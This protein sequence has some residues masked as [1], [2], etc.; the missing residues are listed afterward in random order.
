[1]D[2]TVLEGSPYGDSEG[3]DVTFMAIANP[4]LYEARLVSGAVRLDRLLFEVLPPEGAPQ[5]P[6]G[7]GFARAPE[8][9]DWP[10]QDDPRRGLA[11]WTPQAADCVEPTFPEAPTLRLVERLTGDPEDDGDDRY[12]DVAVAFPGHPYHLEA[13]FETAPPEADYR[14]KVND[15][16]RVVVSRT[17]DPRLYRSEQIVLWQ[18]VSP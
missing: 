8:L 3:G 9:D 6:P 10:V 11:V 18:E 1:V 7:T 4:G 13:A 2:A 14:V 16:L 12:L 5:P 17:A 15:R